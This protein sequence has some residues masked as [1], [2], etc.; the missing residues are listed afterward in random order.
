MLKIGSRPHPAFERLARLVTL[1]SDALSLLEAAA[2]QTRRID[3]RA[4]LAFERQE[5]EYPVLLLDGWAMRVRQ[6]ADGGR[7]VLSFVLPGD[8]I[9]LCG[10]SRPRSTSAIVAITACTVCR[11]PLPGTSP[12][13]DGLYAVSRTVDEAHL[14]NQIARL[15]RM[16]AHDRILDLLLEFH[17]RLELAGIAGEGSFALPLTQEVLA[18][19]LGLTPVH[20]NRMLQQARKM[21]ELEWVAKQARLNDPAAL[22]AKLG[23]LPVSVRVQKSW[24]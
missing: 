10:F 22:A 17:E 4:E 11:A 3:P 12:Q 9:G 16:D 15:G 1:D 2:R 21:G 8:F 6:L 20:V 23:R 7:Q 14:L 13:L 5:I 24:R 19:A 18:D